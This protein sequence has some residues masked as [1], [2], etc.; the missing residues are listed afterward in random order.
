[1]GVELGMTC[2]NRDCNVSCSRFCHCRQY[3]PW[4]ERAFQENGTFHSGEA[5]LHHSPLEVISVGDKDVGVVVQLKGNEQP[6]SQSRD[7]GIEG[8]RDWPV[9]ETDRECNC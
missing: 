5:S 8:E 4:P 3:T 6:D 2:S 9:D 7:A 1:M